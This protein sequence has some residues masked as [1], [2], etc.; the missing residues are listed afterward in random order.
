MAQLLQLLKLWLCNMWLGVVVQ[1]SWAL[2]VDQ[3]WLQVLQFWV[4]LI[5]LL[6]ILLR[7]K[8]FTRIQKAVVNQ[9][10]STPQKNDHDFFFFFFFG[11]CLALGSNLQVPLGP[12]N[13][14]VAT[15]GHIKST[16]HHTSQSD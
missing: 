13:E 9:T 7:C 11:A 14:L 6:S 2:S 4:H 10:G 3:F 15:G 5:S 1:N 12:I 16:F 8:G